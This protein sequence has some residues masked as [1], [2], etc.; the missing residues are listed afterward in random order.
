MA[1]EVRQF[2]SASITPKDRLPIDGTKD[3]SVEFVAIRIVV[4]FVENHKPLYR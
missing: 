3:G 1:N 2:M 4:Q